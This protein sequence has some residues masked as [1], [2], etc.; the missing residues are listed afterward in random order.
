MAYR[1]RAT[2]KDLVRQV[3][4]I[5]QVLGQKLEGWTRQEDGTQICNVGTFVL[6]YAYGG[7]A[8]AQLVNDGGGERTI[9]P[10]G[11]KAELLAGMRAFLTGLAEGRARQIEIDNRRTRELLNKSRALR[12]IQ[13]RIDGQDWSADTLAAIADDLRSAGVPVRDLTD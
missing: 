3:E 1:H 10:R 9:L 7:V 11:T 6:D 5:N 13:R 4:L 2:K 12:Q 8:L